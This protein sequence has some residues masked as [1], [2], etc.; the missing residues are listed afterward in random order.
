M[1][2]KSLRILMN[3]SSVVLIAALVV[4]FAVVAMT[5]LGMR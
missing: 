3:V 2:E 5:A 1:D 4:A